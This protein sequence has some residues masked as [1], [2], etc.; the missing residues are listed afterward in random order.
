MD[1]EKKP[2]SDAVT[3]AGERENGKGTKND[4]HKWLSSLEYILEYILKNEQSEQASLLLEE[5]NDR[6]RGSFPA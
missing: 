3:A 1:F 5:L 4:R 6:L 2:T